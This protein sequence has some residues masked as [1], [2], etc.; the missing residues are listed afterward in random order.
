MTYHRFRLWLSRVISEQLLL[1]WERGVWPS[2]SECLVELRKVNAFISSLEAQLVATNWTEMGRV[3]KISTAFPGMEEA[4]FIQNII[5]CRR[6]NRDNVQN[7]KQ[8]GPL[9]ADVCCISCM[10]HGE[11]KE[12]N[13]CGSSGG[14]DRED[15]GEGKKFLITKKLRVFRCTD[16]CSSSGK[17]IRDIELSCKPKS[18]LV[19][20]ITQETSPGEAEVSETFS[21]KI[22]TDI[23]TR[24]GHW[25]VDQV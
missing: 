21:L 6:D 15:G 10:C 17:Q 18:G 3:I 9:A 23:G 19:P 13:E 11:M 14:T 2:S 16:S 7:S 4:Q 8:L 24:A 22:W 5:S 1:G 20:S 25:S 12:M